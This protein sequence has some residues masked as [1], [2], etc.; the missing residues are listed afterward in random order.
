[1][2]QTYASTNYGG[3]A[4]GNYQKFFVPSIGGPVAE[5][6]IALAGLKAGEH[7]LDVACGTG[8]VT[9]MAARQVMPG[10]KVTGLDLNPG[11][12]A[13]ARANTDPD[14]G[15]DWVEA[16]AAAIPL[17]DGNFDVVLCQ[18]SLQFIPNKLAALRE[19]HRVLK[20]SGR[21]LLSVPGPKPPLFAAMHD[22]IARHLSHEGALFLDLV[23]AMHDPRE[24][25][26]LFD[27]AGFHNVQVHSAP[28]ALTVPRPE[29]FLWQ[30]VHSTPLASEAVN[31]TPSARQALEETVCP[32]WSD[33]V[34]GGK[35]RFEVGITTVQ[36]WA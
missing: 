13:T 20:P 11:M 2:A 3:D 24:L 32:K 31:A 17:N 22:G 28:K 25:R 18:M 10:G 27:N 29:E 9:R 15:T 36:A 5:D 26:D 12:L 34:V 7:V 4:P 35:T 1:M 8:V 23:F 6:L 30:Y 16:D 14:L 33:Y 19:M 21:I